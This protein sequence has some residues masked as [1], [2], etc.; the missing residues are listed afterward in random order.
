M[1]H[2]IKGALGLPACVMRFGVRLCRDP[3]RDQYAKL[4]GKLSHFTDHLWLE[5][6]SRL[7]LP[8]LHAPPWHPCQPAL[9]GNI[10]LYFMGDGEPPTP[11]P[12]QGCCDIPRSSTG[13]GVSDLSVVL[14]NH[15]SDLASPFPLKSTSPGPG[16]ARSRKA[17]P[18]A[19]LSRCPG[20]EGPR[21]AHPRGLEYGFWSETGSTLSATT[22]CH[23]S[24][25]ESP[26]L[27]CKTGIVV[28]R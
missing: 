1:S 25:S 23:T 21:Q 6:L 18:Q 17:P 26:F 22:Y 4:S 28:G 16:A 2:S 5:N 8:P 9:Q 12:Q 11:R 7:S 14:K 24:L 10:L 3:G 15:L 20:H 19:Q 13:S 27:S